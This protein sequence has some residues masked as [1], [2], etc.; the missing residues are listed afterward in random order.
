MEDLIAQVLDGR[1]YPEEISELIWERA[2]GNPF[3]TEELT[4]HLVPT[5][6]RKLPDCD[7]WCTSYQVRVGP[8]SY[9]IVSLGKDG[10]PDHPREWRHEAGS[11]HVFDCDI[12]F[13][14]GRFLVYPEGSLS[15]DDP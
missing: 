1:D 5:H 15:T 7:A 13:A 3:Y 10:A 6:V 9:T 14:N 11:T 12:V 2:G 4:R 8:E